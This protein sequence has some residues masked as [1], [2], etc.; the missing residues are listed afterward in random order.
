M[1][2]RGPTSRCQR[3][4]VARWRLLPAALCIT[5]AR[6]AS[7]A[8]R[9]YSEGAAA[10]PAAKMAAEKKQIHPVWAAAKPFVNGGA[11]GMLSTMLIQPIDMI[12]VRIQLGEKGNPVS[13]SKCLNI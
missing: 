7:R 6:F 10:Q 5:P 9:I 8:R 1:R 2:G 3:R 13:P 11:S 12:K 4:L